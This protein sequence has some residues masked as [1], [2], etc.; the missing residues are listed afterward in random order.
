[1]PDPPQHIEGHPHVQFSITLQWQEPSYT[2]SYALSGYTVIYE[3]PWESGDPGIDLVSRSS[4]AFSSPS[5][6]SPRTLAD[7]KTWAILREVG[8]SITEIAITGLL[9]DMLYRLR[10]AAKNDAGHSFA[11]EE[12]EVRTLPPVRT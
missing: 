6:S 12:V 4:L 5:P 1:M 8:P 2:G 3:E 10:I 9:P 7:K 11:S